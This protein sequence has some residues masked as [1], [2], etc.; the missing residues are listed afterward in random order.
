MFWPAPIRSSCF[1]NRPSEQKAKSTVSRSRIVARISIL[2]SVLPLVLSRP[3]AAQNKSTLPPETIYAK[4]RDSVVT[5]L[6]FDSNRAP[7]GQASG[8]VVGK[9]RVVTNYHVVAGS[10]SASIVFGD[11]SITSV[12][13]VISASSPKDLVILEAETGK[14]QAL[15]LGNELQLK[16]GET[17]YAIGAPRGLA[18]SLSSGLVSAFRQNEGQF[19]IQITAPIAPGSSGG[20]LLDTLG[21]VVGVTTSRLREGGF[22][23]AVGASDIQQLLKTPLSVKL[24]LSDLTSMEATTASPAPASELTSVQALFDQKK[25][26]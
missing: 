1:C 24:S 9:N 5:I 18:T 10:S 14:R 11:G 25:I 20:P 6:T 17:I 19:L 12:I 7:I 21:Q 22:G 13:A 23:F 16:E 15:A 2:I 8:F 4:C 26:R 3:V